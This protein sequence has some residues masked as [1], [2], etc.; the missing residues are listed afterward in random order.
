MSFLLVNI[1][2]VTERNIIDFLMLH[3]NKHM[4]DNKGKLKS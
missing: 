4:F 3:Q 1:Q 2:V